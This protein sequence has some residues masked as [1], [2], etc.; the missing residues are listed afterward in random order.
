MATTALDEIDIAGHGA[1]L[2]VETKQAEAPAKPASKVPFKIADLT[3]EKLLNE[4]RK[5]ASSNIRKAVQWGTQVKV[6]DGKKVTTEFMRLTPADQLDDDT[7]AAAT[8]MWRGKDG[9]VRVEIADKRQALTDLAE[10]FGMRLSG[11]KIGIGISD[12]RPAALP[13]P[14]LS[15]LSNSAWRSSKRCSCGSKRAKRSKNR[16]RLL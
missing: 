12:G 13:K 10:H 16:Q 11:G 8:K 14:D 15:K 7:A 3:P 5:I 4:L 1:A 6:V 2:T 9:Q